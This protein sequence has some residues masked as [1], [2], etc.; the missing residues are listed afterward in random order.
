LEDFNPT[1][2]FAKTVASNIIYVL[3][4]A[5]GG[6]LAGFISW[7]FYILTYN[8]AE[9]IRKSYVKKFRPPTPVQNL[10][11]HLQAH[12]M[13]VN[14][15]NLVYQASLVSINK[16]NGNQANFQDSETFVCLDIFSKG[17]VQGKGLLE[18]NRLTIDNF[19]QN[20]MP[21]NRRATAF[22]DNEDIV[23]SDEK[24]ITSREKRVKNPGQNQ[25]NGET[26]AQRESKAELRTDLK[27]VDQNPISE[28]QGGEKTADIGV[29]DEKRSK[30][31]R[32]NQENGGT[33]AQEESKVELRKKLKI[34]DQNP[35]PENGGIASPEKNDNI[36]AI[37][38]KRVTVRAK[39][40]KNQA[41][42]NQENKGAAFLEKSDDIA[43]FDRKLDTLRKRRYAQDQKNGTP[44]KADLQKSVSYL[45]LLKDDDKKED[46]MNISGRM[47]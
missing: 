5:L 6:M 32:R 25:E 21:E 10:R 19:D 47:G 43:E 26:L 14:A 33:L 44:S 31:P 11:N 22:E 13:S 45:E 7:Q 40:R 30:I 2:D 38:E 3:G 4:S 42:R 41:G 15:D 29:F 9:K 8:I 18:N 39:R 34:V 1:E 37:D 24:L 23:A 35:M 17:F 27:I 46:L 20:P 16:E 36:L 12:N 28:S